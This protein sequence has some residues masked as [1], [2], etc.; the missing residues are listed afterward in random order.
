MSPTSYQT[1]PPRVV[2]VRL[3]ADRAAAT[4]DRADEV[5]DRIPPSVLGRTQRHSARHRGGRRGRGRGLGR[6]GGGGSRRLLE[7][8]E[9]TLQV[10]RVGAVSGEVARLQVGLGLLVV[11]VGLGDQTLDVGV[12]SCPGY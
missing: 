10:G 12:Q 8:L 11:S 6:R 1:A 4:R 5:N 3:A 2:V 9:D 7:L